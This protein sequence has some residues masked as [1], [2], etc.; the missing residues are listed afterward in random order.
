MKMGKVNGYLNL[1][2]S[3]VCCENCFIK[4]LVGAPA[5]I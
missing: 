3:V 5:C 4:L 2:R 1:E